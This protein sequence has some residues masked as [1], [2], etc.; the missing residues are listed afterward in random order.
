MKL[1]SLPLQTAIIIQQLCIVAMKD[2]RSELLWKPLTDPYAIV[3]Q[4]GN[5][6][7]N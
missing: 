4:Q 2:V 7:V 6:T 5:S 3:M 1:I